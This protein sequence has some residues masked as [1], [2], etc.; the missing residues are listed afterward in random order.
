MVLTSATLKL[1]NQHR[2]NGCELTGVFIEA[3]SLTLFNE[4]VPIPWQVPS[5]RRAKQCGYT[6]KYHS[7]Q[8]K[9]CCDQDWRVYSLPCH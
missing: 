2:V 1:H 6:T 7:Y 4:Q 9:H 5:I 3:T 8:D